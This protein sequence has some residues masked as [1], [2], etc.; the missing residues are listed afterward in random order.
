M[1]LAEGIDNIRYTSLFGVTLE[2]RPGQPLGTFYGYDYQYDDAGNKLVDDAGYYLRTDEV[3]SHWEPFSPTSREVYYTT[4]DYKN[5]S[6]YA[7][8]DFQRRRFIAQLLQPVG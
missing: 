8:V 5:L 6:F 7:L 2:A 3:V 1:E 4:L